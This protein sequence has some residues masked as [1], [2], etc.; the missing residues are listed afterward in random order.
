MPLQ[1]AGKTCQC[2]RAKN[3]GRAPEAAPGLISGWGARGGELVLRDHAVA[4]TP[5]RRVEAVVG[6]LDQVL[7]ALVGAAL[8]DAERDGDA[9]EALAGLTPT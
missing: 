6:A 4:A 3:Y 8:R 2:A 9:P 7:C 5:L 1:Q